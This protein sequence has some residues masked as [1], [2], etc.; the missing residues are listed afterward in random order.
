M[1]ESAFIPLSQEIHKQKAIFNILLGFTRNLMPSLQA[2]PLMKQSKN[3]LAPSFHTT[4]LY[5]LA[6]VRAAFLSM[7]RSLN[8]N[9]L[10]LLRQNF[11]SCYPQTSFTIVQTLVPITLH[12]VFRPSN[13]R[14]VKM[15]ILGKSFK[16]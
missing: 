8:D 16:L 12:K 6:K 13:S 14:L 9:V 1:E 2:L 7:A 11:R 15:P 4:L 5:F 10:Q 3:F